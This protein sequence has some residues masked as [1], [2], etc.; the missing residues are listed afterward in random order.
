MLILE[1]QNISTAINPSHIFS[2]PSNIPYTVTLTITRGTESRISTCLIFVTNCIP[3]QNSESNWYFSSSNGLNFNTG[4]PINNNSIPKTTL[5]PRLVLY[6]IT[7]PAIYCFTL[8]ASMYGIA[9]I[10]SLIQQRLLQ[11][12]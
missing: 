7:A 9:H 12:A 1:I 10:S 6:K 3:I 4:V 2:S 5:L 11:E 8:I